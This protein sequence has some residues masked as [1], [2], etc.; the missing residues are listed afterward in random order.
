MRKTD[1][2][3][4]LILA[5]TAPAVHAQ[6]AE[7][8]VQVKMQ[9]A[10]TDSSIQGMEMTSDRDNVKAGRVTFRVTNASQALVHE[11]I[12]LRTD[13]SG[14]QLPYDSKADRFVE[15]KLKSL[16]EVEGLEPGKSGKLTLSLTPGAYLLACNQI[17]HLHAGMWT[18]FRVTP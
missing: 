2:F 3:A 5:A 14:S 4:G 9:D 7:T 16:G 13:L 8:V 18:R 17:G 11:M 1:M 10:T 6:A 15:S 12:V